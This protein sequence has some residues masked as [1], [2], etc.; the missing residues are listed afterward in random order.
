MVSDEL[1][2]TTTLLLLVL[3]DEVVLDVADFELS[4]VDEEVLLEL[5]E[6]GL[7]LEASDELVC[8]LERL[9][10]TDVLTC[11][12]ADVLEIALELD[13]AL[14]TVLLLFALE[15]L[16]ELELV[17]LAL[18]TTDDTE[19]RADVRLEA[20]LAT[21]DFTLDFTELVVEDFPLLMAEDTFE[22]VLV[23]TE[24]RNDEA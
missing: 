20:L 5:D 12:E 15:V 9:E 23:F 17:L 16:N 19:L 24:D 11:E 13:L 14:D 6:L 1:L 10:A 2:D 3:T 18:D 22:D 8:T 4:E 7:T 21:E